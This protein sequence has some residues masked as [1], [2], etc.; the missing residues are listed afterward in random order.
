MLVGVGVAVFV[1]WGVGVGVAVCVA[2]GVTVGVGVGVAVLVGVGVGVGVLVGVGGIKIGVAVAVGVAVGVGVGVG[3]GVAVGVGV[4]VAVLVGVGVGVG[5]TAAPG[6]MVISCDIQVPEGPEYTCAPVLPAAML[7]RCDIALPS[8]F[9]ADAMFV[10]VV[11][12]AG[13]VPEVAAPQPHTPISISPDAAGLTAVPVKLVPVV[14]P[15][16]L[17]TSIGKPIFACRIATMVH[18][19]KACCVKLKT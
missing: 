16:L 2:V 7:S 13:G 17:V 4:G 12:P 19:T 1:A 5:V 14:F 11:I 10:I 9:V 15:L 8:R 6:K 3:V 18:W